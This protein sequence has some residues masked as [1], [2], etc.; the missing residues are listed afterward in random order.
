[1]TTVISSHSQWN[2]A[3]AKACTA[4][5]DAMTTARTL[6]DLSAAAATFESARAEYD[7]VTQNQGLFLG[8][9]GDRVRNACTLSTWPVN[10]INDISW[11]AASDKGV[12]ELNELEE[13]KLIRA[14]ATARFATTCFDRIAT[15]C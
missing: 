5:A 7:R 10:S 2:S 14:I 9:L 1:M 4:F 8:A 13:A 3:F 12:A 15:W 11:S 6:G